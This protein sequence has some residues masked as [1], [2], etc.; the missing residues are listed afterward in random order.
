MVR[1]KIQ[2]QSNVI[3]TTL[4]SGAQYS[5]TPDSARYM[6]RNAAD[7]VKEEVN[8]G[9]RSSFAESTAALTGALPAAIF[10]LMIAICPNTKS[11][12]KQL[13]KSLKSP[14]KMAGNGNWK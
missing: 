14:R 5:P 10:E 6:G 13:I 2:E 3:V 1:D 7:V 9:I 4:N 12:L 11:N 8:N